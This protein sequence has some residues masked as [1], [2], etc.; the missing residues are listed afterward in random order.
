MENKE[1]DK[2]VQEL[3]SDFRESYDPSSWD[4]FERKLDSEQEMDDMIKSSLES[5][6]E[7]F[8]EEHWE[9]LTTEITRRR[10]RTIVKRTA[11][12]VIILLLI[13]T[14]HNFLQIK[15]D[16]SREEIHLAQIG[17]DYALINNNSNQTIDFSEIIEKPFT[18]MNL[19]SVEQDLEYTN[20]IENSTFSSESEV[21]SSG[22]TAINELK[23]ETIDVQPIKPLTEAVTSLDEVKDAVTK[24]TSGF[25]SVSLRPILPLELQ[26]FDLGLIESPSLIEQDESRGLWIGVVAGSDVNFIN[27]PF[28]LNLLKNPIRSQSGALSYGVTV[29]KEFGLVEFSTGILFSNKNYF[30]QR[31]KEFVPS[32]NQKYLET[33]LISLEFDQYQIPLLANFHTRRMG[34]WSMFGTL[35]FSA[36]IITKTLYD[37][38]T[39]VRSFSS[40][41][42]GPSV[43]NGLEIDLLELPR[44]ALEDGGFGSNVYISGIAGLGI[45]RRFKNKFGLTA[46]VNYQR[47]ISSEINPVINR[48]QLLGFTLGAKFNLNN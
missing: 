30:P 6:K 47:S 20:T 40:F 26:Q 48:T 24:T 19:T 46:Q 21:V 15:G 17:F 9:L 37:V 39:Q 7:P 42:A 36:N 25:S 31:I 32:L 33:S 43:S 10:N 5:H 34:G 35:G 27:S 22:F 28:D 12:V 45:E 23:S 1:F 2:K 16:K 3:I 41:A 13:L 11:E 14:T 8:N 4:S 44:G 38:E 29:S 18:E